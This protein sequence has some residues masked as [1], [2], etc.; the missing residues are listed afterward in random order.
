MFR[1]RPKYIILTVVL[2]LCIIPVARAQDIEPIQYGDSIRGKITDPDQGDLYSFQA[3][4]GDTVTINLTSDQV[5]VYLRLGD[6]QGN[7]IEE[8]DDISK[9][10]FSARIEFTVP[11]DGEYIIAALAYD[12]GPYVLELESEGGSSNTP[13]SDI[14]NLSYG[15]TVSGEAI[16]ID[17]AVVY[18]FEGRANDVVMITLSSEDVDTYLVLADADGKSLAENDDIDKRNTNSYVEAVLPANGTYLIG[19]FAYDAGPF[20]LTIESSGSGTGTTVPVDE[21]QETSGDTFTGEINDNDYY[22]QFPL[23]N[24]QDGDTITIDARATSGDLDLYIGIFY[25]DDVVAENDDR[26]NSTKDAYLE[27]P[28][29]EA[30]D[31]TVVVTRY[32]YE[33]GE[34]T[35]EFELTIKVGKGNTT[36][37]AD[38]GT[39]VV[40]A[41][42]Y[43]VIAPTPNIADWTILVYMGADNNLEDGLINDLDEFERAG[44]STENVRI[45]ALLDRSNEYDDSNGDWTDTRIYEPGRDSS[46]DFQV[47]YPPTIDSE[48]LAELDEIDTAYVGNLL[49]FIVWGVK[50]YPAQHYAIILNDHG[51]AWYG[52][53]TDETTGR[54]ILTIPALSQ[55]FDAALKNTGVEKFDL[56]INDA[57]LMS[58]VEHYAAMARYF[59]YAIGS[60]EITLNPSFDMELLTELL[61]DDPGMDM[62]RLGKQITDKYLDDMQDISEDTV[63]VLGANVTNLQ[64]FDQVTS[65]LDQFTEVVNSNPE[66]YVSLLGQARSN[67][68]AYSFFLPEDQYGPPTTIDLGDFMR[69]VS[70]SARG[71]LKDAADE[72]SI[73]LDNVRIYGTSGSQ[74][75]R[76]TSYYNI[77]FP[78]RSTDFDTG[79]LQQT[80]LQDW[81]LMLRAFYGGASP[82]SRAIRAPQGSAA[83]APSSIP[84]VN[85]T[86]VYPEDETSIALPITISMEVT[87]R[88]ISQGKFTVDQI[89]PDGTA[90]RLETSRIITRVVIDNVTQSINLWNPGVD[91]SDFTWDAEIPI[92]SDGTVTSF[93]QVVTTE[94]VSS[95]AG[96]YQYPGEEKWVDVTV[97]F[98]D[99]NGVANV[100]TS[101]TGS[102]ALASATIAPGGIFQTYKSVVTADG[103]VLQQEGTSF[104]WPE[105][106]LTWDYAP[107]PT[108]EYNLGFLIEA[109]G[110]TTGFNS[111]RVKVNNDAVD[112]N[113]RG[114][115][116]NDWGFTFQRPNGWFSVDYFPDQNFLQTGSRDSEQYMFVY[117]GDD[118]VDDLEQIAEGVMDK[119]SLDQSGRFEEVEI[120]GKE[121]LQF[122]FS[123]TNDMGEYFGRAVA[124][125][126]DDLGFGLVF[127]SE[128]M[129]ED[130]MEENYQILLDTVDFFDVIAVNE[131]DTGIWSRDQFT[132]ET[133]YPVP[134]TWL[135]GD[136]DI[137]DSNW[138]FYHPDNDSSDPT[139]AAVLVFQESDDS[140]EEWAS[141]LVDQE[142]S[143]KDDFEVVEED[144]YYGEANT[145]SYVAFTH[146]ENGVDTTG[147]LYV[148]IKNDV[149]YAL[150]FEAPTEQ[151]NQTFNSTFTIMLDGFTIEDP[152][153]E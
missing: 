18:T 49:D 36:I 103:R 104:T 121:G 59:D 12:P 97:V 55:A 100:V 67:T 101:N 19:V 133:R 74:L 152:E 88:N 89:Q 83:L 44:G 149:P 26:D 131:K 8:N 95:I 86:N 151:F 90:V 28:L 65:A 2:L 69:R 78:Q 142:V 140:T 145:W 52:T 134:T 99:E 56:L 27:Y 92:I 46:R 57:C 129:D 23:E 85:I 50:S 128:A 126:Q 125:Y 96:R 10:N 79:Y 3:D 146:S 116:D 68:Y 153:S 113:L 6:P 136:E 45:L 77:Y 30:G 1:L 107:A 123:Y 94:G 29:A 47:A 114:Y 80:P 75:S 37:V 20:E 111:V 76:Y 84:V 81:A 5:D 108:G 105:G 132:D 119:F 25:G 127:S 11:E 141:D 117:P 48:P 147:R 9:T 150:W 91:D 15:D 39:D 118:D 31:Y 33:Q 63:P 143:F 7:L 54:G 93:E 58:S 148:T 130:L 137:R 21:Q 17:N 61:N 72:V 13:V 122:D 41:E 110:G 115:V 22:L 71:D 66:A 70:A 87:G 16:D 24:V 73:A 34:T 102:N 124:V 38:P 120:G 139:F 109:V 43:P 42:G 106:G 53:V 51:G 64:D 144:T 135:P 40:I 60:P 4:A 32:G 62:G 138:W 82:Q 14:D 98:N 35:G 112:T